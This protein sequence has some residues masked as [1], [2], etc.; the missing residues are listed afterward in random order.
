[1]NI[2]FN[3]I[4]IKYWQILE[5]CVWEQDFCLISRLPSQGLGKTSKK[6][7]KKPCDSYLCSWNL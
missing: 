3:R 2:V 6:E 4:I 5:V 1:M 7:G